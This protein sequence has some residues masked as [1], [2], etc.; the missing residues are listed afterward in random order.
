VESNT[1]LHHFFGK[2]SQI[3]PIHEVKIHFA[4]TSDLVLPKS[5]GGISVFSCT[6]HS[7]TRPCLHFLE[8][9]A[10]SMVLTAANSF[11][12]PFSVFEIGLFLSKRFGWNPKPDLLERY[13]SVLCDHDYLHRSLKGCFVVN[14]G[15][16][17]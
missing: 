7:K 5:K 2:S 15:V 14:K 13:L 4:V 12:K 1:R 11:L 3:H 6:H 9:G 17:K 10:Y 16:L 8:G